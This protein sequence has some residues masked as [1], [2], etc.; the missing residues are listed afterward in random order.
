IPPIGAAFLAGGMLLQPITRPY[1]WV[2][3]L[4][5]YGALVF[6]VAVPFIVREIWRTSRYNLLEEYIGEQGNK[7]VTL[8]L[9]R[10][11]IFTIQ[12]QVCRT[13]DEWGLM[14]LST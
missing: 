9:F 2:A 11:G 4:V 14:Q 13:R 3:V 10:R 12:V 8:R 7:T 5:D 6:L 1:A